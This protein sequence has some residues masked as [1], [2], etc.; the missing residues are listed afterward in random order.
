[1][2]TVM[3]LGIRAPEVGNLARQLAKLRKTNHD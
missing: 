3:T 1:M 2:E